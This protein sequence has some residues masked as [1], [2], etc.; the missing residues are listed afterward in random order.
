MVVISKSIIYSFAK[1]HPDA[2]GSLFKWYD[3]VANANWR[4]FSE[5]KQTFG[6]VDYVGNDRYVFDLKGNHFRLIA[7]IIFKVRTIFIL[8]IGSH[9]EYDLIDAS[10]VSYKKQQ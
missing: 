3:L 1:S 2:E 8:F 5:M 6:S 9:K 10:T 7:L 4:N